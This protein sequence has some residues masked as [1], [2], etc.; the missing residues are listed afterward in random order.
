M[1]ESPRVGYSVA[2]H[3][4]Q[5]LSS[6]KVTAEASPPG[7]PRVGVPKVPEGI[8]PAGQ[9]KALFPEGSCWVHWP[10]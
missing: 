1:E 9:S 6:G 5:V 7:W 10:C 8:P 2:W 4:E 3:P